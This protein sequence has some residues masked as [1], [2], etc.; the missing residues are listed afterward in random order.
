MT[1]LA[2]A[3]LIVVSASLAGCQRHADSDER[4]EAN[5]KLSPAPSSAASSGGAG[6]ADLRSFDT[7]KPAP[8]APGERPSLGENMG[9]NFQGTL[10][11]RVQG[12]SGSEELRY[13][14]HGN[15]ARLQIDTLEAK[16]G[17]PT[18]HFD[19]LLEGDNISIFDHQR[20]TI[21]VERLGDIQPSKAGTSDADAK[22][23]IQETGTNLELQG[24]PCEV[25]KI[26]SAGLDIDA[27]VGAL[28]GS[29][30]VDKLETVSG[31]HVPDW[32]QALLK[33]RRLPL[34]AHARDAGGHERYSAELIRY[35]AAV[36]PALLAVPP[37]Y[38]RLSGSGSAH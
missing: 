21:R 13:L 3:L 38:E 5:G 30:D 18:L 20:R 24:A 10:L 4:T 31:I 1:A 26:R 12:D 33:R 8:G 2:A 35:D 16:A 27:C 15:T 17:A 25:Y 19:A 32:V 34:R 36:D 7:G 14:S 22:V 9:R 29:F 28:P 6:P 11:V 23:Q 37:G